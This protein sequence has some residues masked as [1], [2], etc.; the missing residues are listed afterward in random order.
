MNPPPNASN[1]ERD[2]CTSNVVP[3]NTLLDVRVLNER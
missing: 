3:A 1:S 2:L